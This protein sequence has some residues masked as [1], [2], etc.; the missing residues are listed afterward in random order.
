MDQNRVME[1]LDI[2]DNNQHLTEK[3]QLKRVMK[4]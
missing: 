2:A 3:I 1:L 4:K